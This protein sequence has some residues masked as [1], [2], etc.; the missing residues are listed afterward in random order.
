VFLP[1]WRF[2]IL[3]ENQA[4]EIDAVLGKRFEY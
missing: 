1:V 4:V 3:G 2:E